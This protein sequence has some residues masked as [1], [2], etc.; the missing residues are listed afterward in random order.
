MTATLRLRLERKETV[1]TDVVALE[2][3]SPDGLPLP[4]WEPGAHLDLVLPDGR[5]RSYSLCGVPSDRQRFR[6]AVRRGV[7]SHGVAVAVHEQL[8]VG[9]MLTFRG[10]RN[11]FRLE[12]A[13]RYLFVAGGIGITPILPMLHAAH[14]AGA[15]WRLLYTGRTRASMPFLDE[16]ERFG[17]RVRLHPS[18]S[19]GRLTPD[20]IS[21]ADTHDGL[22]YCCGPDGLLD[23]VSR[24]DDGVDRVRI[25]RFRGPTS[26][27]TRVDTPIDVTL[28]RSGEVV[29]VSAGSS[30]L[31]AL[32]EQDVD[33]LSDCR[34][35]VCGACAVTV[36]DG[37]IEH[38]D[39]VLRPAERLRGDIMTIC[40][41][42]ARGRRLVLDL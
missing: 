42:R 21:A 12:P 27:D 15:D 16:L 40:V 3:T 34:E 41:S 25:E 32:L 36:L 4:A 20:D 14:A 28:A 24:G 11:H 38:R 1:A 5:A 37:D 9:D 8:K 18:R 22:V 33:V 10:P 26:T 2:L 29:H 39:S 23:T 13:E 35:G 7:D 17:S 31:D 6:L 19:A 30:I